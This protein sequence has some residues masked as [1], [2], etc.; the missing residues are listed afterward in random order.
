MPFKLSN[1]NSN[2]A[3]TPG[4]LDPVLNNS[5]QD[6]LYTISDLWHQLEFK[7]FWLYF[8]GLLE[9]RSWNVNVNFFLELCIIS[10]IPCFS[11]INISILDSYLWT[12]TLYTQIPR[13]LR[14][15]SSQYHHTLERCNRCSTF[16][17][18]ILS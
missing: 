4:Y 10:L 14:V 2:L 17:S 3:L 1:L 18:G 11:F 6:N 9:Y 13:T 12:D 16:Y 8:Y 7:T 5:A 15:H